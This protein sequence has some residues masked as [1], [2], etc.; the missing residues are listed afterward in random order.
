MWRDAKDA[1]S[2]LSPPEGQ[3]STATASTADPPPVKTV[4]KERVI[5]FLQE[6]SIIRLPPGRTPDM[7]AFHLGVP[8]GGLAA[9][10]MQMGPVAAY[11]SPLSEVAHRMRALPLMPLGTRAQR[12]EL[13]DSRSIA[14]V[15]CFGGLERGQLRRKRG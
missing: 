3:I 2:P 1:P 14:W 5:S 7:A 11:P 15:S 10:L 12:N 13:Q 8:T 4:T 9:R 6:H